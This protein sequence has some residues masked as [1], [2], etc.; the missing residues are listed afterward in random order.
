MFPNFPGNDA[1]HPQVHDFS[2]V[3]MILFRVL[4]ALVVGLMLIPPAWKLCARAGFP[5]WFSFAMMIPLANV[6]LLYFLAFSPWPA[7][8]L[9]A[10]VKGERDREPREPAPSNAFAEGKP[11]PDGH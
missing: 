1:F 10:K 9:A 7:D 8:L 4:P 5:R 6:A 3:D 11:R 2:F